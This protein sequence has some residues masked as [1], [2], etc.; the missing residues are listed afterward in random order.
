M[1]R[2]DWTRQAREAPTAPLARRQ[3]VLQAADPGDGTGG[4][5]DWGAPAL[6]CRLD[7]PEPLQVQVGPTCPRLARTIDWDPVDASSVRGCV[8]VTNAPGLSPPAVL[9]LGPTPHN[10]GKCRARPPLRQRGRA[11]EPSQA[12]GGALRRAR[13]ARAACGRARG[14]RPRSPA[15]PPPRRAARVWRASRPRG[16]PRAPRARCVRCRRRVRARA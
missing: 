9:P 6:P 8:R 2:A 5:G 14:P 15:A 12:P 16:R 4:G 3:V 10:E 13:A 1:R 7:L 11:R